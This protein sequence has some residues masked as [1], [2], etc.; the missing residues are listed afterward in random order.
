[1][2]TGL[3]RALQVRTANRLRATLARDRVTGLPLVAAL[4]EHD[5]R[6][7]CDVGAGRLA[8]VAIRVQPDVIVEVHPGVPPR[9][10][11]RAQTPRQSA[12]AATLREVVGALE[13]CVRR[14]DLLAVLSAETLVVLVP[15]LDP[16]GGQALAERLRELLLASLATG[17]ARIEVGSAF[18]SGA[19][20][21]G[22]TAGA[23]AAEAELHVA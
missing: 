21:S 11:A 8:A 12:R 15:G 23:L 9:E 14:T 18:R 16:V 10:S 17:T 7:L 5:Q 3:N 1:M 19:S 22:W 4:T 20:S 13:P 2:T 6:E